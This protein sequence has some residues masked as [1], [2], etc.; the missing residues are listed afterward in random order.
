M[1]QRYLAL[2][3]LPE[4][5]IRSRQAADKRVS[6]NHLFFM[7]PFSLLVVPVSFYKRVERAFRQSAEIHPG[8][9]NGFFHPPRAP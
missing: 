3:M 4:C 5:V 6:Q 9:R 2:G 1:W 8:S 7:I